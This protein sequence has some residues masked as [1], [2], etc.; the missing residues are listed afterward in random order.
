M[1]VRA[2]M[3]APPSPEYLAENN[4]PKIL[5]IVGV[6]GFLALVIVFLRLFVRGAMLRFTGADDAVIALSMV[7][8]IAV[9]VCFVG[10]AANGL[11][12]H[13]EV[14]TNP[15]IYFQWMFAHS[16]ISL[17]GIA[18]VKV[19]VSLLLLRLVPQKNY[20]RILWAIIGTLYGCTLQ[21]S[22]PG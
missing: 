3:M 21:H 20:R 22:V 10:E 13:F 18:A 16:L 11:G 17:F 1:D 5:S 4:A 12:R 6:F 9:F 15:S 14:I 8:G 2:I 19:S 7:I